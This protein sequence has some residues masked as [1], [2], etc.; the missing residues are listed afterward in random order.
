GPPLAIAMMAV[1]VGYALRG[2][3]RMLWGREVLPFPRIFPDRAWSI[4][5]VVVTSDNV[6]V[7][8]TVL[9]LMAALLIVFNV[10]RVG[11]LLQA[12]FQIQR[13]AALIGLDVEPVHAVVWG[14][15]A[16]LAARGG[17]LLAPIPLL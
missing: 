6:I 16:A 12:A 13:G 8:G 4:G 3:A 7:S 5:D 1:A 2:G 14:A 17:G 15:V 10:T 11:R 9:G